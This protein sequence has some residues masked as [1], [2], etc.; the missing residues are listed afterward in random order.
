MTITPLIT[1]ERLLDAAIGYTESSP[2]WPIIPVHPRTKRPLIKTGRDHAEHASTD[3]AQLERWLLREYRGCAIGMP[4]GAA[5]GTV[6]IDGDKK[7]NGEALLAELEDDN[8]LG[9]L[10]RFRVVRTQS[11]GLHI[12]LAHP[13]GGIRVRSGQGPESALG[14]LLCGRAGL[15]VRADGGIVVLPPSLGY[16]WIA[17]DDEPLPPLPKLWLAAIN[18]TEP[19]PKREARTFAGSSDRW[20]PPERGNVIHLG[21]RNG[22]LH[23]R[24]VALKLAGATDAELLDDLERV[25]TARCQP[26]LPTRE[27]ARIA[28]SAARANGRR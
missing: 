7:H 27:V 9:P 14:K 3:P 6:V 12:Y 2:Q 16:E 11:G 24:G 18:W 13:G 4:T 5:S 25:N 20:S 28:A 8:V 15:D 22:A 1:P 21:D 26:P 19:A 10:P 17:D 23:R